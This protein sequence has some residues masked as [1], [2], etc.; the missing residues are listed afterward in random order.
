MGRRKQAGSH[1]RRKSKGGSSQKK[2]RPADVPLGTTPR[3][4][5][6]AKRE[7]VR[8]Y[9]LRR[10]IRAVSLFYRDYRVCTAPEARARAVPRP[11]LHALVTMKFR[12]GIEASVFEVRADGKFELSCATSKAEEQ[13]VPDMALRRN[14]SG[15][16]FLEPAANDG[17]APYCVW[18]N[19]QHRDRHGVLFAPDVSCSADTKLFVR[20][21][22]AGDTPA[23]Y[24][25]AFSRPLYKE[26][27]GPMPVKSILVG[28]LLSTDVRGVLKCS[29]VLCITHP[30]AEA[31]KFQD[32][33]WLDA[34]ASILS[35]MIGLRND[36]MAELRPSD[37]AAESVRALEVA[38]TE[39]PRDTG[40]GKDIVLVHLSD[41]HF[42]KHAVDLAEMHRFA[43]NG[44]LRSS[45]KLA[46]HIV[47]E[48]GPAIGDPSRAFVIVSG[49]LGYQATDDEYAEV[50]GS[51]EAI[52]E[53]LAIDKSHV[54][55]V[56]GNHDVNWKLAGY[57]SEHRFDP[58][59]G[60][61]STFYGD[62]FRQFYPSVTGDLT[63][64]RVRPAPHQIFSI[65]RFDKL[66]IVFVGFN[67]CVVEDQNKHY[68]AIG[69]DQL[70]LVR[71][72]LKEVPP[73]NVR[74]AVMHHHVLPLQRELSPEEGGAA[75]DLSIVRDYAVIEHALH[76]LDFDIVLH[77]HKHEPGVRESKLVH[78]YNHSGGK[79]IVVC[80]AGSAG[81]QKKELP[82]GR[83]NHFGIYRIL[84]GRR[85]SQ[86]NFLDIEWRE[87]P[88][89]DTA[90][91]KTAG[92]W[93]VS[94]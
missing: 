59:L 1:K 33:A 14:P 13:W 23:I 74:V 34:C 44:K 73:G 87:L 22:D 40:L 49:D 67:S 24:D 38:K 35:A 63:F 7:L 8:L 20:R 18:W 50:K 39:V 58:F 10:I 93:T 42:G 61:V 92:R 75:F 31:F 51:L 32:F 29:G 71:N 43:A 77:G 83:G 84:R 9:S 68:G 76:E 62:Q 30:E 78:A 2:R 46:D 90:S 91:W 89:D 15:D 11:C 86:V 80:G 70:D 66:G 5:E 52:I 69:Q 25:E 53:R 37:Q 36:R 81:V 16:E 28:P 94:G 19:T 60:F 47:D 45:K 56:P 85:D 57:K 17:V 26:A 12:L 27:A 82:Q 64:L 79:R 48:C 41:I 4:I 21:P 55:L 54:V 6:L 3:Q 72:A 88:Y 65:H